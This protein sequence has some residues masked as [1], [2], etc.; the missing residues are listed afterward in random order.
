MIY[1]TAELVIDRIRSDSLQYYK[2]HIQRNKKDHLSC[3]SINCTI[4]S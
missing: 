3:L 4:T 1:L 2:K